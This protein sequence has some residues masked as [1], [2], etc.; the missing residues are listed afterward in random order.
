MK[1]VYQAV[2]IILIGCI[3]IY[4][5]SPI[6]VKTPADGTFS[7]LN[8]KKHIDV[9]ASEVH[10]M[11]TENNRK[12]RDYIL[13]EFER[14]NIPTEVFIGNSSL[15]WG[16]SYM[17]LGKT[18]NIIATIKGQNSEKAVM[19]AGHYDSVLNS[20]AAADDIHA[21]ANILETAR[22]LKDSNPQNDII[23]LITDGEEM[24]LIGAKAYS[25]TKDV[26]DIGVL[27]NYESRGN[28]GANISFEW[29]DG[30]G[31]LVRQLREA[32]KRPVANSM[33]YEIYNQLPNDTDFTHFKN[34]G[35]SG[36]N[37][38]FIDGFS[39]YH[40][41][42]DNPD[43]INMESV[44]HAGENM[45]LLTKHFSNAD[46]SKTVTKNASFFNFL[47]TLVI[48]PSSWDLALVI[49]TILLI[50]FVLIMALKANQLNVK[51]LLVGLLSNLGIIVLSAGITFGLS[52]LLFIMYPQYDLFYTG[53]FYN[54]KWYLLAAVGLTVLVAW[55]MINWYNRKNSVVGMQ[56]GALLILGFAT[57]GMFVALPTASYSLIFPTVFLSII[58]WYNHTS[59]SRMSTAFNR[60]VVGLGIVVPLAIWFPTTSTFF[61]A[62]SLKGLPGPVL[63]ICFI[64]MAMM[65]CY[66]SIWVDSKLLAYLGV[67]VFLVSMVV[68]H[69]TSAPTV[70]KPIPSSAYFL[71]DSQS[72]E[73][74]VV[75]NDGSINDGNKD[76][77]A[78]SESLALYI[79]NKITRLAVKSNT[80]LHVEE[81]TIVKDS[82]TSGAVFIKRA[83][84]AY[85]TRIVFENTANITS[86][87]LDDQIILTD[88]TSSEQFT[89]DVFGFT[90]GPL[91]LTIVKKDS[92]I[93]QQIGIA[94]RFESLPKEQI[95]AT[96]RRVDGYTS[97]VQKVEL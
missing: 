12:V 10:F 82:T 8:A 97:I 19:V 2:W 61:L 65:I 87:M 38:A 1:Q 37:N 72:G 79:P 22:L 94:S 50:G 54:H 96:A 3:A 29:S 5:E 76:L 75:T 35:V 47:G 51:S 90:T 21:V 77:L 53:Q 71:H 49:L 44:Q 24:G 59:S 89:L 39:Y 93:M 11:G 81:P 40:N 28:S 48:Y 17:R 43:N 68:G 95:P 62:F 26:S 15:S 74:Y 70:E 30:N 32:A 73:S 13:Q 27:L 92:S 31:W 67:G 58:F 57:L 55:L 78:G 36:I 84:E 88:G 33:S 46:F 4:L 66:K 25:E 86:A 80:P 9:M 91:Q 63:L 16:S 23:F 18:E 60:L 83:Q 6:A 64:G 52:K 45:Y 85:Q 69:L 56:A 14:M 34:A 42:V 20:P 7:A 41:P